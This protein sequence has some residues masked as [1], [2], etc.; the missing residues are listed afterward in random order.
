LTIEVSDLQ[1]LIV[2]VAVRDLLLVRLSI[3]PYLKKLPGTPI[4]ARLAATEVVNHFWRLQDT[5]ARLVDSEADQPHEEFANAE[6]W[7][8]SS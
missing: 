5:V 2:R 1:D 6:R 7:P 4:P 3:S 8:L